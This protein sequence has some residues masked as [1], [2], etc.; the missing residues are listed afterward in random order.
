MTHH[1]QSV[2][3]VIFCHNINE[4]KQLL[5][6]T[7]YYLCNKGR[8]VVADRTTDLS[9]KQGFTYVQIGVLVIILQNRCFACVLYA[10]VPRTR[11]PEIHT[12]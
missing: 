2:S 8:L 1:K 7:N 10:Y 12:H 9:C 3:V 11:Y 5:T 6:D 4:F